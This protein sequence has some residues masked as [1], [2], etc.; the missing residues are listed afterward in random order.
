MSTLAYREMDEAKR[1]KLV[2]RLADDDNYMLKTRVG[3]ADGKEA[4][5]A[6][7][8]PRSASLSLVTRLASPQ[9]A[10]VRSHPPTP[11]PASGHLLERV[12][13]A[14]RQTKQ[15]P[16]GGRLLCSCV[17]KCCCHC[18]VLSSVAECQGVYHQSC[19]KFVASGDASACPGYHDQPVADVQ[20]PHTVPQDVVSRRSF[21][22]I[23]F[24]PFVSLVSFHSFHF[25]SFRFVHFV[26]FVPNSIRADRALG[27][28][29]A[30]DLRVAID[31]SPGT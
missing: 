19:A 5:A 3:V 29:P 22:F 4:T 6:A 12:A 9:R 26:H 24:V 30:S 27:I 16:A 13:R 21:H 25:I 15:G 1:Y 8:R 11:P 31:S 20:P 10:P 28:R 23:S 2:G 18:T 14:L 17:P 7:G